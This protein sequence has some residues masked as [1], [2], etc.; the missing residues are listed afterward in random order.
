MADSI[1]DAFFPYAKSVPQIPGMEKGGTISRRNA[2]QYQD[3]LDPGLLDAVR[4]GWV[5]LPVRPT[6]NFAIEPAYI[7]A[8]RHH[9]DTT[10]LGPK[11]GELAA[12]GGGRPFPEEPL[13]SD[14][15]A[16][17]K[18]A[19]NF[20]FRQGDGFALKPLQWKYID[21]TTG[22]VERLLRVQVNA[23]KYKHR[24]RENPVPDVTPNPSNLYF[25]TYLKVF[26]P[27]DYKNTQLLIQ[28]YEDDARQDDSYLY[29][30]FQ[31]RVR[32]LAT[33]QTT[34]AFLG[35]DVMIEDFDGYNARVSEMKWTYVGTRNLLTPFFNHDD[36]KLSNEFKDPDGFQYVGFGGQGGCFPDIQWQLRKVYVVEAQPLAPAHPVSKRIFYFDAQTN[37]ITRTSIYDRRGALWKISILGKSHPDH[38]LPANRGSGSPIVDAA[39]MIDVQAQHC[40]TAQFK[41]YAVPSMNSPSM[42]QVQ[43]LRSSD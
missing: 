21:M 31:R 4:K 30:G 29:L 33:G 11:D 22:T 16:G 34:D 36:L 40:S 7:E 1:D 9:R 39:S 32:R 42:F 41:A 5:E 13:A 2:D 35:S 8:T 20:R 19:W 12:Y 27:Q 38:H 3:Y 25:A 15:R 17:E 10:R 18:I 43:T 24:T 26:E 37:E 14:P 28:R 23:M 6:S